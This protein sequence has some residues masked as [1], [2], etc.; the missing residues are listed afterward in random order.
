MY[1]QVGGFMNGKQIEDLLRLI[2]NNMDLTR[3][4]AGRYMRDHQQ[5]IVDSL[6]KT[7]SATIRTSGGD[8]VLRPTDLQNA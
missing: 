1:A 4:E 5:E 3:D 7:G 6:Y 8:L 2:D